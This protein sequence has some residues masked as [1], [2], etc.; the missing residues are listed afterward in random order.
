VGRKQ[1]Y[2]VP[3]DSDRFQGVEKKIRKEKIYTGNI[4]RNI[5]IEI[6]IQ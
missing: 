2:I 5:S 4:H 1:V 6:D 3:R